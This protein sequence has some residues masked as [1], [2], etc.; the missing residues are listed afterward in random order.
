MESEANKAKEA[1]RKEIV[2]ELNQLLKQGIGDSNENEQRFQ[3][4]QALEKELHEINP[5]PGY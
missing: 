5:P 2:D 1:R 3:K 4:I